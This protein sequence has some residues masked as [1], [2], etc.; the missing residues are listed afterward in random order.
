MPDSRVSAGSFSG[1]RILMRVTSEES[2]TRWWPE[3]IC[4]AAINFT[5]TIFGMV[6]PFELTDTYPEF[7]VLHT[8]VVC[9]A[10][11]VCSF[12]A[13]RW[14][15]WAFLLGQMPFLAYLLVSW[16]W[17][18]TLVGGEAWVTTALFAFS[19]WPIGFL[20]AYLLQRRYR[21]APA[22]KG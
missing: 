1:S 4:G 21:H 20:V 13:M 5:L 6:V 2:I 10:T 15:I 19:A 3:I 8:A 16:P 11:V 22:R 12:V 14:T 18:N 9:L 17:K 7:A